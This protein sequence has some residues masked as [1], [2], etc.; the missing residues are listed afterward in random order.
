MPGFV[1]NGGGGEP[2]GGLPNT[3]DVLMS[4]RWFIR[5]LG[6][7]SRDSLLLARDLNL[8]T[9]KIASQDVNGGLITYKFAKG[10]RW[11]DVT[12]VFYD[13]G[14]VYDEL[15]RWLDLVYTNE[16]GIGIH[17]NYK[18]QST[19]DLLDG[20]GKIVNTVEL[21]N[22]WPQVVEQ[23]KLTYTNSEFKVVTLVLSYDWAEF[24]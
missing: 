21:M 19:L 8:P 3:V 6:P 18:K 14:S 4:H 20:E 16:T 5:V 24:H 9:L 2:G 17:T 15:Q 7:V 22:S 1:I 12:I 11:D 10:V 23:G 13:D